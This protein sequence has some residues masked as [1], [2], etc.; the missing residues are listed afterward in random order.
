M[1]QLVTHD[2]PD[3][4]RRGSALRRAG[5]PGE[6]V[7]SGDSADAAK[8]RQQVARDVSEEAS[9]KALSG[10]RTACSCARL[11]RTNAE[12]LE[13]LLGASRRCGASRSELF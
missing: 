7:G 1:R 12:L 11:P 13:W 10:Q 8:V 5:N 3:Q 6:E 9:I 4:G 2:P